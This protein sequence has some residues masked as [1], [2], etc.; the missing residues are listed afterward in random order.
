MSRSQNRGNNVRW[1][2]RL[3]SEP[4]ES[5]SLAIIVLG[6]AVLGI[7]FCIAMM[8]LVIGAT[9][10][11]AR[12]NGG[13]WRSAPDS[14]WFNGLRSAKGL[15]CSFADGRSVS[16][17]SWGI[18]HGRYWVFVDGQKVIVPDDALVTAPNHKDVAVVW[19]YYEGT[20][21]R[22]WCFMPGPLS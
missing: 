17:V 4:D 6:M 14:Q 11:H 18:E 9:F 7:G 2:W 5:F 15:C 19:P 16:V 22:I 20:V 21:L 12:E 1:K 13:R 3:V 8:L 10:G